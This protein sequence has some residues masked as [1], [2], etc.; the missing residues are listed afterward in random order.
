MAIDMQRP[1]QAM[2]HPVSVLIRREFTRGSRNFFK[3]D[4]KPLFDQ[5]DF[6]ETRPPVN[7]NVLTVSD[8]K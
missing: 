3:K 1:D 6:R 2:R 7:G 8:R 4:A 5:T